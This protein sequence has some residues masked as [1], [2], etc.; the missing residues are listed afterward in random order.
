LFALSHLLSKPMYLAY[1][2][3]LTELKNRSAFDLEM[4]KMIKKRK[5][6]IALFL[7]DVGDFKTVNNEFG[8]MR[9]DILLQTIAKALEKNIEEETQQ[10]YRFGG[11]EFA[12]IVTDANVA[13]L[14]YIAS[15]LI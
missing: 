15:T 12:V 8:H 5:K 4:Q 7:I 3:V 13:D 10:V 1:H 14:S 6:D 9:G 2:D 11:D